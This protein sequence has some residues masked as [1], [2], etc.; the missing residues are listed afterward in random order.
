MS[1]SE[2]ETCFDL[3][4]SQGPAILSL[5]IELDPLA[6]ADEDERNYPERVER[7]CQNLIWRRLTGEVTP[8]YVTA[9]VDRMFTTAEVVDEVPSAK[10]QSLKFRICKLLVK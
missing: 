8:E 2:A 7:F 10:L 6:T 5:L 3:P 4:S 9:A 1:S